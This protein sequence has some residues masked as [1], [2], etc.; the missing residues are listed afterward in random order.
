MGKELW[1]AVVNVGRGNFLE[2][3]VVR[4]GLR[5]IGVIERSAEEGV[6]VVRIDW[7]SGVEEC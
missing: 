2:V 5:R 1:P 3:E 4:D 6:R 7:R